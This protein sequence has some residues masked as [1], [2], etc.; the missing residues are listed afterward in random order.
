MHLRGGSVP[1]NW[2]PIGIRQRG[3]PYCFPH[4]V[5]VPSHH[6]CWR[7]A[8]LWLD[9]GSL[10]WSWGI[11]RYDVV[12]RRATDAVEDQ[13]YVKVRNGPLG[14][15]VQVEGTERIWI[16]QLRAWRSG[17]CR[18]GEGGIR[19]RHRGTVIK[20]QRRPALISRPKSL[21]IHGLPVPPGTALSRAP[22]RYRVQDAQGKWCQR[23]AN[24]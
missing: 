1:L 15:F 3:T 19:V 8:I 7:R 21:P 5:V 13:R 9:R 6:K 2:T 4:I 20:R 16:N 18:G 23:A 11:T 24:N 17:I 10:Q 14:A 12:P 22:I